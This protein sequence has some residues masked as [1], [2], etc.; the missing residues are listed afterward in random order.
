MIDVLVQAM[1]NLKPIYFCLLPEDW[2]TLGE[3]WGLLKKSR[4]HEN[5]IRTFPYVKFHEFEN[6]EFK[7]DAASEDIKIW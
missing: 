2:E 6:F 5:F 7:F 4:I 3:T 1:P